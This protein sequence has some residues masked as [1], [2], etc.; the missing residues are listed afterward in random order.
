MK[1]RSRW[2]YLIFIIT[3]I[4]VSYLVFGPI[5]MVV[6][7]SFFTGSPWDVGNF[8]LQHFADVFTEGKYI[9]AFYNTLEIGFIAVLIAGIL[10]FAFSWLVSRSDVPCKH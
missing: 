5:S 6:K 10:G 3:L 2:M 7:G 9:K 1:S 4:F 8:T